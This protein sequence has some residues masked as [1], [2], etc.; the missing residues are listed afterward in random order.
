MHPSARLRSLDALDGFD[1]LRVVLLGLLLCACLTIRAQ[2]QRITLIGTGDITLSNGV[3]RIMQERGEDYP[4]AQIAPFLRQADIAFGNLECVLAKGGERLPK[5]FNF[6]AHPNGAQVLQRAGFDIVSLANNH[7]WDYGK[8][9]LAEMIGHLERAGVKHV[10]A[11]CTLSEA[12]SLRVITVRG[13][14]VG[15]LAYLGMFP[16]LIPLR[17]KEP[18]VAMGYLHLVRRDVA[19]A[20][21]KVDFLIVS[22]HAGIEGA[23]RR[24][25]RQQSIARTAVDAGADMVI[26]HH[27]HVL[28]DS[29]IYRDKPIFYSL[30]N[31]I[32]PT[33]PSY[34]TA[35]LVATL[36]RG[37]PPRARLV[38]VEV[39][40]RQARIVR[41]R[42][43]RFP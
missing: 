19:A 11:G 30:G 4:F 17:A 37:K 9:G 3:A 20:R 28:Q 26:G 22:L 5:Q 36:E 2:A 27:P 13:V 34:R 43:A 41:A 1:A 32:F 38:E 16:P 7:S 8:E 10:G 21:K 40:R 12:H 39:H 31:F 6:R 29:E 25:P 23:P 24:S 35:I 42:E 14:R 33:R 15:F 18:G